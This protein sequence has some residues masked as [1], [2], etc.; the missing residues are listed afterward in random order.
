VSCTI[1]TVCNITED[2]PRVLCPV[3]LTVHGSFHQRALLPARNKVGVFYGLVFSNWWTD[4]A[5]QLR[6]RPVPLALCEQMARQLVWSFTHS[7]VPAQQ[8]CL[9]HYLTVSI[10]AWHL[11]AFSHGLRT[12]TEPFWSRDSQWIHRKDEDSHRRSEVRDLQG[13]EW[14]EKILQ[15]M[16]NSGSSVQTWRQSLP[17][18]IRYL[19]YVPF[20]ETLASMVSRHTN[21]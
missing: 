20:T 5:R 8:S 6:V 14:H 1:T 2:S 3:A 13:T 19:D 17:W 16:K 21:V 10:P 9:L 18:C 7:G 4:G 12:P 11:T 15:L